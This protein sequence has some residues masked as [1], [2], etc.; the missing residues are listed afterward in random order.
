M[1]VPNFGEAHCGDGAEQSTQV[2]LPGRFCRVASWD[3]GSIWGGEMELGGGREGQ[4]W[5]LFRGRLPT[6]CQTLD[7]RLD[8][9]IVCYTSIMIRRVN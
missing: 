1:K 2:V 9:Q 8:G 6:F 7:S 4:P 3:D 5:S